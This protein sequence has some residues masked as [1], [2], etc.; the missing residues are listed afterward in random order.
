[1]SEEKRKQVC[2]LQYANDIFGG[3]WKMRIICVLMVGK[4]TKR[5]S[6][7]KRKLKDISNMMLTQSLKELEA[8]GIVKRIQFNEVP[9]HVEYSLTEKGLRAE[10]FIKSVANWSLGEFQLLNEEDRADFDIYCYEC[11]RD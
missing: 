2:P 4:K 6:T 11:M 5:Y 3:K 1:M 9:P 7:I 8:D 10:N